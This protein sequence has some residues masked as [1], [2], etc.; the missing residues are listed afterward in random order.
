M[1]RARYSPDTVDVAVSTPHLPATCAT[2]SCA[3]AVESAL[4]HLPVCEDSHYTADSRSEC[5]RDVL[6]HFLVLGMPSLLLAAVPDN[7]SSTSWAGLAIYNALMIT[8]PAVVL[9][10]QV[11]LAASVILGFVMAEV[12]TCI[13]HDANHG[14]FSTYAPPTPTV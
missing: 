8:A 14:A 6:R 1:W 11:A 9:H 10:M 7:L 13:Q 3:F 2:T 4:L 5:I 12:G